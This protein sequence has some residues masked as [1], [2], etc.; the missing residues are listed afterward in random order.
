M[1]VPV[2]SSV[3]EAVKRFRTC[4]GAGAELVQ[5]FWRRLI[6]IEEAFLFKKRNW[7]LTF[8]YLF[9]YLLLFCLVFVLL[10]FL[11]FFLR[12]QYALRDSGVSEQGII[13][14]FFLFLIGHVSNLNIALFLSPYMWQ[15]SNIVRWC[16]SL[17][18]T[19]SYHFKWPWPNFKLSKHFTESVVVL[20]D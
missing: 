14:T 9:I 8:I 19:C 10:G 17:S 6:L 15:M 5:R 4:V 20:S 11:V 18:F 2:L 16:Y 7:A 1:G 3:L 13:D 12:W